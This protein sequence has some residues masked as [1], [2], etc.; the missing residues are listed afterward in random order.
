[1]V[2]W[3]LN[4]ISL[5]DQCE[6]WTDA[7]LMLARTLGTLLLAMALLY[8]F[9]CLTSPCLCHKT[10]ML[11]ALFCTFDQSSWGLLHWHYHVFEQYFSEKQHYFE[12]YDLISYVCYLCLFSFFPVLIFC[13]YCY[14]SWFY[15]ISDKQF[16]KTIN[17]KSF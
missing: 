6:R 2:E 13:S 14:C 11:M 12:F 16:Q 4:R 7:F 9:V 3:S 17:S 15:I 10:K 1:M 5:L 8:F